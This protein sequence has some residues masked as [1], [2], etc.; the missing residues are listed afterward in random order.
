MEESLPR[1]VIRFKQGFGRLI[2][3]RTD[4]GR[5]VFPMA[6]SFISASPR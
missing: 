2:R 1:A 6:T 4:N 3:S 5:V